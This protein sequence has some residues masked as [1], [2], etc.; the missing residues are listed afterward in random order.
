MHKPTFDVDA[1]SILFNLPGYRV[2]SASPAVGDRPR[3]VIV[4]TITCE[5][6]CPA[7]GVF[8][9]R[10]QARPLQ[11]VK[12]VPC[13]GE[14]LDVV[15]KRRYACIE[16]L[17][18]RRS[19]TEE[20]D[21]LPSRAR[22][23]T[24]LT[25][26]VITACRAEP[27]AVSRVADEVAL[28]WPT[29]M[30]MLTSTLDLDSGVDR[31]HVAHLG[32][33]EHRFRTVRYLRDPDSHAVK[34]VEPWS[35]V[36]TDLDDGS[37]LDVVDG[38]RGATVRKW[39]AARPRWWR[40]RVQIVALDMSSEFRAGVRT[41]L[42]RAKV[43]VDHWHVVRLANDMGTKVRRRRVWELHERRGRATDTP[44]KY[45]K[46]LTCAGD[47]LTLRQRSRLQEILAQDIELAVAWGIKEH[48][49]QLLA[50]RDTAS[51]QRHWARLASAVRAT[52]LPEPASLMRT[53]RAWRRE[54]LTFCRSRVTNARTEAANLTAKTIKRV[55]RGY[56]NHDNYRCRIIG[57]APRPIAA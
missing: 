40:K 22:V 17:C 23:T 20:T 19:F 5:G 3:Q 49:R 42:P 33:D 15:R 54:L 26:Q 7:C 44:W 50:A 31:R 51:F 25:E 10:V 34:R 1:A 8:S 21:Q 18:P 32:I 53:L 6:A 45:R 2:V 11:H 12:D 38:R 57:Y 30:R 39:L 24:R 13:G 29:V 28:A 47:R 55:G 16:E 4:E 48:V 27:R 36:F 41:A 14:R 56:R 37:I 52:R 35:I 43:S 9:C 46:L